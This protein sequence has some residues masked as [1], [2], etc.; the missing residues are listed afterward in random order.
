MTSV[1]EFDPVDHIYRV[2]DTVRPSVTQM[3]KSVGI[4]D[5]RWFNEQAAI[6]GSY[7]HKATHLDDSQKGLNEDKLDPILKPYVE[8]YRKFK[9][10]NIVNI[11]A[12][13]APVYNASLDYCGTPDRVL[14]LNGMFGILDIKSGACPFWTAY[15]TMGYTLAWKDFTG[16]SK[17]MHRWGLQLKPNGKYILHPF[18][19][20]SDHANFVSIRNVFKLIGDK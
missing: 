17:P 10:E 18:R 20:R 4:I 11:I 6:R 2:G 9:S 12:S 1:V 5:D 7:V 19:D 13:E 16:E 15:Q 3:I 14:E 8:A